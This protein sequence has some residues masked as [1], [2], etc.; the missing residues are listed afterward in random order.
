MRKI[1]WKPWKLRRK[2]DKGGDSPRPERP[3]LLDLRSTN[4]PDPMKYVAIKYV[5]TKYLA[6]SVT[7]AAL[8]LFA[9]WAATNAR[10][11]DTQAKN[12]VKTKSHVLAAGKS[13]AYVAGASHDYATAIFDGLERYS[14]WENSDGKSATYQPE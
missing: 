5:A 7:I 1:R 2:H 12:K 10:S 6:I 9:G 3:E 14:T 4:S 8:C 13:P 11:D